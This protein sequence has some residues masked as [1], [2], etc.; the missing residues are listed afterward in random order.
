M[1][2]LQIISSAHTKTSVSKC[3]IIFSA[4]TSQKSADL[5]PHDIKGGADLQPCAA[6]CV[7]SLVGCSHE[8]Y[9]F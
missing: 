7:S 5:S 9:G 6:K 3:R 2:A 8:V 4:F 1:F